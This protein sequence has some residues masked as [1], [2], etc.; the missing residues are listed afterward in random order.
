MTPDPQFIDHDL[1]P[2]ENCATGLLEQDLEAFA[3]GVQCSDIEDLSLIA[4]SKWGDVAA[5]AEPYLRGAINVVMNQ[6]REGSCVAF[7]TV[8]AMQVVDALERG[9]KW[10]RLS[11][12]SL[13][14]RIGRTAQSGAYIVDGI[15]EASAQ[16]VLPAEGGYPITYPMTGFNPRRLR[17]LDWKPVAKQFRVDRILRINTVDGWFTALASGWPIVYGRRGHAIFSVL[18]KKHR[19]DWLFG[20][21]NSWGAWGDP[22]NDDLA[23]GMGWDTE[24][25]IR[26]CVG[27]AICSVVRRDK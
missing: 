2:P 1:A 27:Y 9:R 17:Q 16:G 6:G 10:T 23:A 3:S 19:G 22:I 15:N 11:P 8:G 12:M 24:R 4:R 13:Y 20:Y 14:E 5:T 18:P 25:T 26:D 7:A 21:V